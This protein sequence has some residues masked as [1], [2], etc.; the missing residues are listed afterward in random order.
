MNM[1]LTS[2]S[3][4]EDIEKLRYT[5]NIEYIDAV[6]LWCENN[7]IEVEYIANLIK[8]DP[9]MKAKIQAEAENLNIL[10]RGARLPI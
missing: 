3:F 5:K 6:V 4:I 9:A 1:I 10:K 2:N 8:K 7:K